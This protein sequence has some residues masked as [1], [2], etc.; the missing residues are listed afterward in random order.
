MKYNLFARLVICVFFLV[1]LLTAADTQSRGPRHLLA[2]PASAA[3]DQPELNHAPWYKP[4]QLFVM[5]GFIA[6]TTTGVWGP[7]Y[8]VNGTW[9]PAKQE[10][11]LRAWEKTLG[12]SY[13]AEKTI[14]EFQDA[15]ATGVIFY[16]KWHDGLVNHDTHLTDFKTHRDF[17][18]VTLAALRKHNMAAVVYYS[19][20]LDNNPEA[21]FRDWT[22]LDVQGK[23][24][25]LA[26][27]T[28]WKS[29]HSPYRQYVIDQLTEILKEDGP[30][31]GFWLDLYTQPNPISY[32]P[33]TLRKFRDRYHIA[34]S[35]ASPRQFSEFELATLRDFLLEIR[36][37]LQ[38]IQP[39]LSFTFNG[40]GM[41]DVVEPARARQ[42]DSVVDW[43]SVEGHTWP[44]I[45]RSSRIMHA[46]DRPWEEGILISS[47]WYVP[48]G[49]DAPAPVES[50]S[51]AVDLAAATWIQGGNAYAAITP[52]H[53]GVYDPHGDL[54]LLRAMGS[55]LKDNRPW[56]V[57][58]RPYAEIGILTGHPADD[59]EHIPDMGELWKASHGFRRAEADADPGRDTSRYLRN[60]GYI[61]ERVGGTFSSRRFDLGSYRMLLLP[62]TALLSD[63]DLGEIKEY[64]RKGGTLLSFGHGSLFDQ[65]G[66]LKSN[67][68]L[69]D[70]FGCEYT[71]TLA[72]YKRLA[73]SP[74]SGLAATLSLYPGALAVKPTTGRVLAQWEYAGDSPAIL[75]N[76]YGRGRVIYVSAEELAFGEGSALL[77]ELA[78]RLI[79]APAFEVHGSRHYALLVNRKGDDLLCYLLNRDTAPAPYTQ[80]RPLKQP[81]LPQLETPEPVRLTVRTDQPGEFGSVELIPSGQVWMSR[82]RGSIELNF[83]ATPS[84]TTVRLSRPRP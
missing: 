12:D 4:P 59:V 58:A 75:E 71:G 14:Q 33:F 22:C 20:G 21:K 35:Q 64:V 80:G 23:P 53:A 10:A 67:F 18:K 57:D 29:F 77:S 82:Q 50:P 81:G 24:M 38:A 70:L 72:G 49:D 47:S 19:V 55:W 2:Q 32:D 5:T 60:L 62:E 1:L 44:N 25:G 6:N 36:Q 68:A 31:D 42:V 73:F 40:A 11:A 61:T 28:E 63:N 54:A 39:G 66:R 15:G 27:A 30:V 74:G 8:I 26:F 9:S 45:D 17:V 51:E 79:G 52:G 13:D 65:E 43:F 84:V 56:L 7:E 46:A 37:K 69:A 34:A 3:H 41:A 76:T 48:P 83:D 16:D 78:A